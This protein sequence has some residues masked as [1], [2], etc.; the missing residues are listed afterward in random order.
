MPNVFTVR[1][2]ETNEFEGERTTLAEA[3]NLAASLNTSTG[4]S[5]NIKKSYKRP[6]KV[7]TAKLKA[8]LN[9]FNHVGSRHHY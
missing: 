2:A 1:N 7:G 6:V 8:I 4:N 9:D 5:F 3:S